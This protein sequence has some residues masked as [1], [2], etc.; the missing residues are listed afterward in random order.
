MA[1]CALEAVVFVSDGEFGHVLDEDDCVDGIV[2]DHPSAHGW[3]SS[4]KSGEVEGAGGIASG[5]QADVEDISAPCVGTC[6]IFG[7][8]EDALRSPLDRIGV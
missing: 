6:R 1:E 2:S 8:G 7:D 5:A 4:R 3:K